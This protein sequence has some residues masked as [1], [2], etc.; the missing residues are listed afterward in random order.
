M[1]DA[2]ESNEE[3]SFQ[4][5]SSVQQGFVSSNGDGWLPGGEPA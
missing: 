2:G 3:F 4:H 1:P 5:A